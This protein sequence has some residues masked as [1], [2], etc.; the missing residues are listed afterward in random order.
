MSQQN[1]AVGAPVPRFQP[2]EKNHRQA[3]SNWAFQVQQ[4]KIPVTGNVTL[5]A[6]ATTTVVIDSRA[7]IN[8]YIGLCPT[9]ANAA[10]AM[11]SVW[12]SSFGKQ[13][14]T[15]THSNTASVDKS[16]RYCVLG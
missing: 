7:G 10:S 9:T 6:S 14:F 1:S 13:T 12:V 3:I 8:S 16:F 11:A 4:G 2:N 15:L 5:N